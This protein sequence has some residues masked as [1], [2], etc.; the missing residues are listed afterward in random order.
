V[1][2]VVDNL[3]QGRR[4]APRHLGVATTLGVVVSVVGLILA[5]LSALAIDRLAS[6]RAAA[7]LEILALVVVTRWVSAEVLD[8]WFYR[9]GSRLRHHWRSI[10]LAFFLVPRAT[11]SSPVQ[12]ADAID[13]IVDEPRLTVVRASAQASILALAVVFLTG[14]WQALGIVLVLL[15]VAVPLYQRAGSR[16]AA[17]DLEYRERRARLGERQ[18]ELLAHAPELRGLGAVKYGA[19]EIAALSAAEHHVALRAIR[20]ALGS[21]LVTEFLGGVS[22]GLVAMDVGFGLLN[23]RVSLLRALVCVLVTSEFF[24]H[25]RRY[26]VEFHRREAIEAAGER[27]IVP[28]RIDYSHADVLESYELVT[29][30]HPEPISLAINRGDR[31]AVLGASGVG[32]TTLAHTL[33]GWRAARD[34]RVQRTDEAVA[35]VSADTSLIEGTLGENL[36]LGLEVDDD[37]VAKLLRTLLLDSA[38]FDQLD[39]RVSADGEGFSSGERVR[40]LIARALLHQPRLLILDDVAGLLDAAAREAIRAELARHR[41]MAIIEISVDDTLFISASTKVHLA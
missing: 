38:R 13:T 19:Q 40:I 28:P 5:F 26:G 2:S 33:L 18:L 16:A 22:V 15:G 37:V 32:K 20:T 7:G 21:S 17:L 1:T 31:V 14:G 27:L 6:G 35:Y 11:S 4:R 10:I 12:I 25:V 24:S 23:G 3:D 9:A 29:F 8:A 36:R 41:E 30:A 34:G 39:T